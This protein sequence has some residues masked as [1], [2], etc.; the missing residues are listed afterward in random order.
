MHL[1]K[2]MYHLGVEKEEVQKE[3]VQKE[4]NQDFNLHS[5]FLHSQFLQSQLFI[6]FILNYYLTCK[7]KK[8]KINY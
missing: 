3:E 7:N 2:D 4:E 5:Q 8:N 1:K 6:F